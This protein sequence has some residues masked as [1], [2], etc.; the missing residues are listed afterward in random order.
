MVKFAFELLC[1]KP[2]QEQ[3]LLTLVINKFVPIDCHTQC[4]DDVFCIF[5]V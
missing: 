5:L 2:E 4:C 3:Q 1:E